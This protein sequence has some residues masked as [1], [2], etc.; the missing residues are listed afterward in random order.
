MRSLRLKGVRRGK[1]I[2]TT[3]SDA[4]AACRLDRVNRQFSAERSNALWVA[5]FT[6]VKTW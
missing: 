3:S 5:D 6:Y 2:K 4:D 1:S